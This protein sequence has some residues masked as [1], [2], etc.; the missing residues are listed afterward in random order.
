V[1]DC[2]WIAERIP[3]F[4]KGS[5]ALYYPASVRKADVSLSF[6]TQAKLEESY[7][8]CRK[9]SNLHSSQEDKTDSNRLGMTG[10][11]ICAYCKNPA[12]VNTG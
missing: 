10:T 11:A 9:D 4:L 1:L 7:Y 3:F 8:F 5:H 6:C 12:Y 2:L